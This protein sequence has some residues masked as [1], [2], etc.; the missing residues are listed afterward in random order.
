MPT[1]TPNVTLIRA[2]HRPQDLIPA[3]LDALR[4]YD[5][6]VYAA[7]LLA[8]PVPAYVQ[9]EGDASPWWYGADAAHLLEE[10]F[11]NLN[12]VAPEGTYFGAH[13][14]D[15]SA[16]V[17]NY[18]LSYAYGGGALHQ[19]TSTGGAV[20]DVFNRGHMPKRELYNLLA[21]YTPEELR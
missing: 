6:T 18:H 16:C 13:P 19:M 12:D 7:H 5:P 3:F 10:L 2:T 15:G 11:D 14:G 21:Y 9:D 1:P 20:R 4:E 17:G 8:G